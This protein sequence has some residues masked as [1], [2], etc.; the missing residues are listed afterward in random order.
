[1]L[2]G[3]RVAERMTAQ[4]LSQAELA[5]RV[6]ISQQAIGKLVH[7]DSRKTTHI[8]RLAREL[9]TTPAFLEGETDDPAANAPPPAPT[10]TIQFATMQVALPSEAALTRMFLGVL[11]ASDGYSPDELALELAKSLPSGLGLLRGPLI[12][13]DQDLDAVA[14]EVA[15]AP[16]S[17]GR[18]RRRA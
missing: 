1:M 16:P 18:A 9:G 5:R 17:A 12:Y 8:V 6:G 15:E 10:P 11:L 13:V 14:P 4:G 7:G 2:I 3:E